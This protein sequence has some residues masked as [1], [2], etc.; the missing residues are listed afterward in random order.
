MK[1]GS[2]EIAG[3]DRGVAV[4]L[5]KDG[6]NP[7]VAVVLAS[8]GVAD[9]ENA[10]TLLEED[11]SLVGDPFQMRDMDRTVR[12]LNTAISSGEHI[13]VYGD[14]DV[15]GM[16]SSCLLA[17]YFRSRGLTC[18]IYIPDR[19][20]EGY[21]VSTAAVD[22]LARQDVTL[23]VTVDCGITAVGETEH[24]KSLG[25]ELIIT[26]HHECKDVLPDAVAVVDPKRPGCPYPYKSLAGVGVAFKLVCAMES[27]KSFDSL[28]GR[29][30]DLVA[31][32]TIADVMPVTGENRILIRRG[33]AAM[34]RGTRPGVQSLM[35]GAGLGGK[36]L[37]S[38]SIGFSL[39]P[40]L[41]AAGRLGCAFHSIDLLL[42][43][44]MREA[45]KKAAELCQLNY[46]RRQL[47]CDTFSEVLSYL[48]DNPPDGPIVMTHN[49]WHQGI[50]GIVASRISERFFLPAIMI[51]IENGEGRGSCRSY[52]GFNLF[53]ALAHCEDLLQNYGGHALAAGLTITEENIG[54]FK[55]RIAD[56]YHSTVKNPPS[57]T[58]SIDLEVIKPG[59]LT[60]ENVT[61][62]QAMEPY[63]NGNKPPMMCMKNV[64]I[65]S[66]E[67]IGG[68]RHTKLFISKFGERYECVF[69]SRTICDLNI[70]KARLWIW[71]SARKSTNFAG[72][73]PCSCSFQTCAVLLIRGDIHGKSAGTIRKTGKD[74]PGIQ[75]GSGSEKD[76]GCL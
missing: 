31:I 28:I 67:S 1:Y 7:L 19:I 44:D 37:T 39:A 74:D 22:A 29:Y 15:D 68:G 41:N 38:G 73:G 50:L 42:T 11:D 69:F 13:A 48:N 35:T 49:D 20:D 43:E 70:R 6:L 18:D 56:Y 52:C 34:N 3:Y 26:D 2:W 66:V 65:E 17:S 59:L 60:I 16:T 61:A 8:R 5:C 33:M 32:G 30:G 47:E 21:G 45:E 51:S 53:E 4:S 63:G 64:R 55:N 58:L 57:P 23:I 24:A 12:R 36:P 76:P 40:R 14:Y 54:L 62:L 71:P 10:R 46:D 75:S 72:G 25:I 27:E 9:M